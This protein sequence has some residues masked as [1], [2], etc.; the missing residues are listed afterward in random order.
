MSNYALVETL[1]TI[2]RG[3]YFGL[4]GVVALVLTV[5]IASPD[6]A[7]ATIT[8]PVL[9]FT[10]NVG[11]LIVAGAAALAKIVDRYRH[12]SENTDSNGIAPSFLQN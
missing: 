2:G 9:G 10:L 1:K 12:K 4:L 5:I 3:I 8:V 11:S 6:V 7:A